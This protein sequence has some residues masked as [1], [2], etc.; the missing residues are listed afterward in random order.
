MKICEILVGSE[1]SDSTNMLHV[2]Q[3]REIKEQI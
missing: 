1:G 2:E 3:L